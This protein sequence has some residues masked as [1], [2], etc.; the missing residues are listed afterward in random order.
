[1]ADS[2]KTA[3][4]GAGGM[5]RM[6]ITPDLTAATTF[7]AASGRVLDQRR[8]ARL[9]DGADSAPVRAA[10][11]A[12]RNPDGGFGHAIEPDLRCPDSQPAAAAMALR[13]LDEADTWDT[14]LVQ[15]A[16]DWLQRNAAAGGGAT[17]VEASLDGWPHA[18]WWVPVPG[19]PASP[20]QTGLIAGTLH[21]RAVTH[22]W[23][24]RA[25]E[26]MWDLIARLSDPGPYDLL[27][28]LKFLDH[29]PDRERAEAALA[30]VGPLLAEHKLAELD[31]DASG[32]THSPLDFA[33]SPSSLARG[34]FDDATV[35]AH[36]D[37]LARGQRDDGGWT[38]NWPA[39]S[40]AAEADWRGFVTVEAVTVLRA[41]G[42]L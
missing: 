5:D 4:P 3:A 22:P 38:F 30:A 29:V 8:F 39:W 13:I 7:L 37:H 23:L 25:T 6:D 12:Y 41:Y 19:R 10:V 18:P 34:L 16:C 11:A 27:G 20:I 40:P 28:V 42:R 33:P 17:F 1:M 14:G 26:V 15:G 21:A 31:P 32:E 35:D 2:F 24:E 9:L 36:L